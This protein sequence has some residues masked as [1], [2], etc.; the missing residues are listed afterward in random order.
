M[1][2]LGASDLMG[3]HI[4]W[5]RQLSFD[6]RLHCGVPVAQKHRFQLPHITTLC[7]MMRAAL[8]DSPVETGYQSLLS[9]NDDL[10]DVVQR[11]SP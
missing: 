7:S 11:F 10:G 1:M 8:L 5:W 4:Q 6:A 2:R 9:R 3:L